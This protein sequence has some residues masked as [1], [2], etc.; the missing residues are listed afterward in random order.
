MP[1]ATKNQL[2]MEKSPY[3]LSSKLAPKRILE[4]NP[5]MKFIIIVTNPVKRSVSQFTHDLKKIVFRSFKNKSY[6][7]VEK[8][9]TELLFHP[10][11]KLKTHGLH[12]VVSHGLY[13]VNYKYW[14][15]FFPKEQFLIVN[16]ENFVTN[17][18]E[19]VKK[20][21]K[22]LDLEPFIQKNH[23]VY[24]TKKGFFCFNKNQDQNK[25]TCMDKTKG[26]K[27]PNI[28]DD[29]LNKLKEFYKP[30]SI[31]LFNTLN[32]DPFWEI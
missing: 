4:V 17:P 7:N 11:G 9:F 21:E 22:F 10:D 32:V 27:H 15:K 6:S 24:D 8:Y 28:S 26:R 18:Y 31:E 14:L 16:G 23:F 1:L 12:D 5:K 20:V 29:A 19:E 30:Y 2:T 25:I 13:I 3:Y